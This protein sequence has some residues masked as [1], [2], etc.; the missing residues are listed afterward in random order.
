MFRY[1]DFLQRVEF[2]NTISN[3]IRVFS[4]ALWSFI[5]PSKLSIIDY[6][7]Y[8]VIQNVISVLLQT[9][10]LGLRQIVLRAG[11]KP[12][13]IIGFVMHSIL[14]LIPQLL[15]CKIFIDKNA[16]FYYYI[17]ILTS[18]NAIYI[19]LSTR[20]KALGKFG[21]NLFIESITLGVYLILIVLVLVDFHS[22][23]AVLFFE[24]VIYVILCVFLIYF[25]V[26]KDKIIYLINEYREFKKNFKSIYN[27]G[28]NNII[29]TVLWRFVP[30]VFIT[31]L[32]EGVVLFAVY[33]LS[34]QISNSVVLLP[35]SMLETWI[36][37]FSK[38]YSDFPLSDFKKEVTAK[39]KKYNIILSLMSIVMTL[40]IIIALTTLY[41][42]Y[43][44]WMSFIVFFSV[45]RVISSFADVYSASIY[46]VSKETKL[47][48]PSMMG[49]LSITLSMYFFTSWWGIWGAGYAFIFSRLILIYFTLKVYKK[50]I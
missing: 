39:S 19:T 25:V 28:L 13:P 11:S 5:I 6:S 38:V 42:K 2:K 14:I 12:I 37:N 17:F 18:L 46:A 7:A 40:A 8:S 30:L 22:L 35:Q 32:E 26:K 50:Y 23:N 45:L 44:E 31:R 9:S 48:I 27:I 47:F 43:Y 41:K 34:L 10:T 36:P 49:A 21:I 33:N 16:E 29:D 20:L 1:K 3:F 24:F 15:I 4:R